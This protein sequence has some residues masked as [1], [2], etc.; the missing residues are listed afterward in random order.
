MPEP[1]NNENRDDFL[2]RCMIDAEAQSDFPSNEQ[3]YAFCNSQWDNRN[4]DKTTLMKTGYF[5]KS[6]SLEIKEVDTESRIVKGYFSAFN[7][8]DSDGD[9]IMQ[10]AFSKSIQEH[11][12]N[13][14]SNRKISHL[15]FHDVTRPV[16]NLKVLKEDETGLYFESELGTHDDGENALKMY[17]D[18]IIKEH[19]IGF[20]YLQDKTNFI[21][22]EKEKTEHPLVKQLGGYWSISEVKLW[23]GSYVTFGANAE[24][25]N[26][27]NIKSQKDINNVLTDLKE[28][29][30]TFIKAL[31][32]GNYSERYNN[33]F[34]VELIQITKQYESL[35]KFEPFKKETQP[36]IKSDSEKQEETKRIV[37]YLKTIKI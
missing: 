6:N 16:G 29:M 4:K 18:G 30:E 7:N 1:I 27:T 22:V 15:A 31:K 33:L 25:P 12:V 3:R 17:K 20:N 26:L 36:H 11:G 28:R 21:E 35:V 32:D 10:G 19:S 13:S 14:P 5:N 34:E 8:I 37:S 24:T 23:E 2:D 9:M